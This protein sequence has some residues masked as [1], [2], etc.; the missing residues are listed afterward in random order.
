MARSNLQHLKADG[1]DADQSKQEALQNPFSSWTPRITH[2]ENNAEIPYRS[3]ADRLPLHTLH[4]S[5]L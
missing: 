4:L 5:A 3:E 1:L 2:T